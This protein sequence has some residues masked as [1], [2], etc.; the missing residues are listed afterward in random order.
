MNA[1]ATFEDFVN[2]ARMMHPTDEA[3]AIAAATTGWE[4]HCAKQRDAIKDAIDPTRGGDITI[5][6]PAIVQAL[7]G[8]DGA[9]LL[10]VTRD[11][12]ENS[13]YRLHFDGDRIVN[14]GPASRWVPT[15]ANFRTPF[16]D[17]LGCMPT[18]GI[19]PADREP[20]FV[21]IRDV[22]ETVDIGEEGTPT[23]ELAYWMHKYFDA[24][25]PVDPHAEYGTADYDEAKANE[26]WDNT[27]FTGV[28]IRDSRNKT[29][30]LYI[31]GPHLREWLTDG[32][33]A[34]FTPQIDTQFWKN[35]KQLGFTAK[36]L[37]YNKPAWRRK[38]PQVNEPTTASA[39]IVPPQFDQYTKQ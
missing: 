24:H 21:A 19:G 5:Q 22:A 30:Q 12:S 9:E 31:T 14:L 36:R 10:K 3:A 7:G 37:N 13:D 38:D 29:R 8:L 23:G 33:N 26:Q 18:R 16:Y 6:G 15:W 25:Y 28:P 2:T 17:S 39:R 11:N 34:R 20:I 4:T 32:R 35:L 1:N 27:C